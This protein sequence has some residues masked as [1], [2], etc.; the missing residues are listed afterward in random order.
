MLGEAKAQKVAMKN[1]S[2]F[3][4]GCDQTLSIEGAMLSKPTDKADLFA[5]LNMLRGNDH[6]L[7]SS[8]V[9]FE[10]AKPVW[11]HVSTSHLKMHDLNDQELQAYVD[12]NWE[13]ARHSVGG[14]QIEG[15]SI[16][17]FSKISGDYFSILGLPLI[18]LLNY[19]RIREFV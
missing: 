8:A 1:P 9:I 10:N 16:R 13:Q 14:Y 19:L 18:E 17:L 2:S 5:Q 12:E 11:R 6:T 4:I 3:V 15:P 7:F